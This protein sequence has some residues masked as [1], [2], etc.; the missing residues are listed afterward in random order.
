MFRFMINVHLTV[1]QWDFTHG[2]DK[3]LIVRAVSYLAT[4]QVLE[5]LCAD[6]LKAL[7]K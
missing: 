4:N 5:G 3:L 2:V 1:P 7:Y 6:K